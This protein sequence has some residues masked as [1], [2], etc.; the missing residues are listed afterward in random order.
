MNSH[1]IRPSGLLGSN[2]DILINSHFC[3]L[4]TTFAGISGNPWPSEKSW[5]DTLPLEDADDSPDRAGASVDVGLG[6]ERVWPAVDDAK[7]FSQAFAAAR[8]KEANSPA[9]GI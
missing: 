7:G 6:I 1:E 2:S 5:P 9:D 3:I 8:P 4:L